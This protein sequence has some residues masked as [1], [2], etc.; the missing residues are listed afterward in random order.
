MAEEMVRDVDASGPWPGKSV[1]NISEAK[2]F[3][4][5]EPED[6]DTCCGSRTAANPHS[7]CRTTSPRTFPRLSSR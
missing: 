4:K 2:V 7:L 3:W 5:M 1:T 6:Q